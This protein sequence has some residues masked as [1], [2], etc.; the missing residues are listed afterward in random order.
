MTKPMTSKAIDTALEHY[1]NRITLLRQALPAAN[2]FARQCQGELSSSADGRR[3][4][5]T[6]SD[7]TAAG[8]HADMTRNDRELIAQ[9]LQGA[10][11]IDTALA[12]LESFVV[13][14][15]RPDRKAQPNPNPIRSTVAPCPVCGL[16]LQAGNIAAG[17]CKTTCYQAWTRADRPSRGTG[18]FSAFVDEYTEQVRG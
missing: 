7:P 1:A 5:G 8:A 16:P 2:D 14:Y 9:L 4:K 18:P 15:T 11:Q 3:S 13:N 12:R 6:H 10:G 17:M